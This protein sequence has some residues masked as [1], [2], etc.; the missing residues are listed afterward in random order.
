MP[1]LTMLTPVFSHGG[2]DDGLLGLPTNDRGGGDGLPG[3]P[4]N[5]S[6]AARSRTQ[7]QTQDCD[8]VAQS[9]LQAPPPFRTA[10]M[11]QPPSRDLPTPVPGRRWKA[12]PLAG[13]GDGSVSN[14][15]T[16]GL[17]P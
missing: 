7:S 6:I 13:R 9:L 3:L 15:S 12:W 2:G 4:M 1:G 8:F 16:L 10:Q 11:L 14:C 17:L 5:S